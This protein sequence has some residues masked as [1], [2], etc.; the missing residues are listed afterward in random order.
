MIH[1]AGSFQEQLLLRIVAYISVLFPPPHPLVIFHI[2]SILTMSTGLN[3]RSRELLV[4]SESPQLDQ[5]ESPNQKALKLKTLLLS[6]FSGRTSLIKRLEQPSTLHHGWPQ[7]VMYT[8]SNDF[9]IWDPKAR[10]TWIK[11]IVVALFQQMIL[12]LL[13]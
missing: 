7:R 5:L 13:P 1:V 6:Q 9:S 10:S 4:Q 3:G 8:P 11:L 12:G 2:I